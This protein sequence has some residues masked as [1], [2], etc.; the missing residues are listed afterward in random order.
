MAVHNHIRPVF[1][2]T[3]HGK[4]RGGHLTLS[5]TR[6]EAAAIIKKWSAA[7][8]RAKR[9]HR[10]YF[11]MHVHKGFAYDR[12]VVETH[13]HRERKR[14]ESVPRARAAHA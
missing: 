1:H 14:K 3:L 7:L 2:H 9:G 4:I 6:A 10:T 13:L 12:L 8:K 5:I 11:L